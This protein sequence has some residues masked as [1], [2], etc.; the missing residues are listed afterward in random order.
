MTDDLMTLRIFAVIG[1]V[2]T[3]AVIIVVGLWL[4]VQMGRWL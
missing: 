2:A 1:L 4:L 3:V